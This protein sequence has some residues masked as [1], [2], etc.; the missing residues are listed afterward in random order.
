MQAYCGESCGTLYD[1]LQAVESSKTIPGL[2]IIPDNV[3]SA[4]QAL[5]SQYD[6]NAVLAAALH[7]ERTVTASLEGLTGVYTGWQR[8]FPKPKD[9]KHNVQVE[10]LGQLVHKPRHLETRGIFASDNYVTGTAEAAA[11]LGF[12]FGC[13]GVQIGFESNHYITTADF[14]FFFRPLAHVSELFSSRPSLALLSFS[15]IALFSAT[16]LMY[17]RLCQRQRSGDLPFNQTRYIDQ[18]IHELGLRD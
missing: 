13:L 18:K 9:P 10:A 1:R 11:G 12:I 15:T 7:G 3:A 17:G 6:G 16:V 8:F 4:Q 2:G 5:F 14:A